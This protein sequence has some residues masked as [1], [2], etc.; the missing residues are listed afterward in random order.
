MTRRIRYSRAV[1]AGVPPGYSNA[2]EI[3]A[4]LDRLASAGLRCE[5]IGRSHEGRPL[6][7]YSWTAPFPDQAASTARADPSVEDVPTAGPGRGI[8]LLSLLHPMEWIGLEANLALLEG[9]IPGLST[10]VTSDPLPP[11]TRVYSIPVANSDGRARVEDVLLRGRPAWIR[12]NRAGVDLNR[13][14]PQGYRRRPHWLRF[15]PFYR[16]GS[17]PLSEPETA[18]IAQWIRSLSPALSFSLHSFGNKIFYPPCSRYRSDP[19]ASRHREGLEGALA[20]TGPGLYQSG[21]LGRWS[22]FFRACGT[23]IDF[24]AAE[25]GGLAY[26]IELSAGG[27]GRWGWGRLLHPFYLFNPPDPAGELAIVLPA[28]RR[29]AASA[30]RSE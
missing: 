4:R 27:F 30:C 25:T 8:L 14:F 10:A 26:L 20:G 28:L 16:P 24:L 15:W 13:N 3:A 21:Q 2:E 12:G 6:L 18:A 5:Q 9:W 1:S 7:A 11:G 29:L 19:V 23:E 17:G 22:P